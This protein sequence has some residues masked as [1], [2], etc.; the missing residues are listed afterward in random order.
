MTVRYARP[1]DALG[2]VEMLPRRPEERPELQGQAVT[3]SVIW[4]LPRSR[5]RQLA[6]QSAPLALA[7][8]EDCAAQVSDAVEELALVT[9]GSIRQRVARHLLDLAAA[10]GDDGELI[11]AV[12]P[13]KLAEAT[14]SVREVVARVLKELH[15]A[16]ITERYPRGVTI[17][18]VARLDSEA[19]GFD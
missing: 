8:A 15:T 1:G 6:S 12:L 18:D 5:L 3:S 17:L 13:Q 7:I 10:E 11:A 19:R 9:F 4:A 14:G 2:L 16:G